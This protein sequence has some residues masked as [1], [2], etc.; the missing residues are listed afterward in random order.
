MK[1]HTIMLIVLILLCTS[2]IMYAS[3]FSQII[4]EDWAYHAIVEL[5]R[6][7]PI[8]DFVIP[9]EMSR[10]Q[11][12]ILVSRFLQHLEL[13]GQS[14]LR[15]FG[16]SREVVLDNMILEYNNQVPQEQQLS[17][18]Q[19]ELLYRLVYEFHDELEV[20]GYAIQDFDILLE[21]QSKAELGGLFAERR[22]V[23]SQEAL[24]AARK[25][26]SAA[27]KMPANQSEP[28]L[29]PEIS[30]EGDQ[31]RSLWLGEFPLVNKFIPD[32]S[33][34]VAQNETQSTESPKV[35]SIGGIEFSGAIRPV[36]AG[37]QPLDRLPAA[38]SGAGYGVSVKY[39]DLA[40]NTAI[41]HMALEDSD[42][43]KVTSTS[44][45][46]SV[47]VP[48]SVRVSAGYKHVEGPEDV[49][50]ADSV[51]PT[52]TSLGLEVPITGG[53]LR[54]GMISEWPRGDTQQGTEDDQSAKTGIPPK[55]TAEL[56]LSY[57]FENESS[58]RFNYRFIDFSTVNQSY[59]ATAEF[60]IKF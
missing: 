53:R 25:I 1:R 56:G 3:T 54:L 51:L 55:N 46:V 4:T 42:T 13:D 34:L 21:T 35:F 40:L 16:I 47:G 38:E 19:V 8:P 9:N 36:P 2:S 59:G 5:G 26:E 18:D 20:L 15:R 23:Y 39:G 60:S 22:L 28:L 45:D 31:N 57:E 41:D 29:E 44:V 50:E 58:L 17:S 12:A 14:S 11:G 52:V 27:D 32:R 10:Y 6:G 37:V 24:A 7:R 33:T 43:P 49:L 48:D 30:L